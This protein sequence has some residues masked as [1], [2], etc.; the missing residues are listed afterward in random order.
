MW[1]DR[2]FHELIITTVQHCTNL[3]IQ[4]KRGIETVTEVEQKNRQ[5]TSSCGRA[6]QTFSGQTKILV[7][8][9]IKWF[10]DCAEPEGLNDWQATVQRLKTVSVSS[11]VQ[12]EQLQCLP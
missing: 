9:K 11:N 5:F 1:K 2:K 3:Q 8:S 4:K 12:L 7:Q 10:Y 6:V